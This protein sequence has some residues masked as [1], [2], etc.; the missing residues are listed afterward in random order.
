MVNI[1]VYEPLARRFADTYRK[2]P[3]GSEPHE[4]CV[5]ENGG[6]VTERQRHLFDGLPVSFHAHNNRGKD[7]GGYEM[8]AHTIPCDLMLCFGSHV[9]FWK[10]GWLDRIVQVFLDNGPGLYGCWAFH[11]PAAHI[12]TT[13][14][15][16]TPELLRAYP[17]FV[18]DNQR[19]PFE[20]G[21]KDSITAFVRDSGFPVRQVTWTE[22]LDEQHWRHIERSE[23]LL[24][25]QFTAPKFV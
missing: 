3:P 20:H 4:V 18:G 16:L 10:A 17:F 9:H 5:I 2:F 13:A 15:W 23:D 21:P 19:Y 14:F 22:V 25:D 6:V 8:A 11:Q 1:R 12:R 7:I 24:R